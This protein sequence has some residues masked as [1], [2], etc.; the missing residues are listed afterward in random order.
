MHF[1][2]IGISDLEPS[3]IVTS[4]QGSP[5]TVVH[6]RTLNS[7]NSPQILSAPVGTL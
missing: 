5:S 1:S 4:M 6:Q 3:S 7:L 2:A